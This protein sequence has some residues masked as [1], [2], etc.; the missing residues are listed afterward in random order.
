MAPVTQS[1]QAL[2]LAEP[3]LQKMRKAIYYPDA[4]L[5]EELRKELLAKEHSRF[6]KYVLEY[7]T[8]YPC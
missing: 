6:N 5:Q 2:C 1:G 7:Y 4:E 8:H 3:E